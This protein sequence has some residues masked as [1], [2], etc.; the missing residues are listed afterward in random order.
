M[1]A[2]PL[3]EP[4]TRTQDYMINLDK[5]FLSLIEPVISDDFVIFKHDADDGV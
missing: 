3:S 2:N 5:T 1:L 4:F